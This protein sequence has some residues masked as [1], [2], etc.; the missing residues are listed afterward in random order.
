MIK[1]TIISD[2][3]HSNIMTKK[4]LIESLWLPK[5][6]SPRRFELPTP[7]LGGRCSI[8]LSYEDISKPNYNIKAPKRIEKN[9]FGSSYRKRT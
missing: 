2:F 8:Q 7:A 4:R 9:S 1:A 6:A 3:L 5:M